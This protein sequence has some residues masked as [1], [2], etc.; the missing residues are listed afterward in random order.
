MP[1]WFLACEVEVER[2]LFERR[3]CSAS[4]LDHRGVSESSY[5]AIFVKRGQVMGL[6][7]EG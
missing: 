1:G 6:V 3:L 7:V 2:S 5:E 4:S